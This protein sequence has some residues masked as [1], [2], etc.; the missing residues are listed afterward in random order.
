M[1][2]L[3]NLSYE[4]RLK[5]LQLPTLTERRTKRLQK[6]KGMCGSNIF[7]QDG[8]GKNIRKKEKTIR[9]LHGFGTSL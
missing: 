5:K 4:E 2:S 8:S 3:R 9:C 1:P 7:P 6:G